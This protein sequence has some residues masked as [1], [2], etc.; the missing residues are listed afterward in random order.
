MPGR[1]KV[2]D[3][4]ADVAQQ[5]LDNIDKGPV[6]HVRSI[7]SQLDVFLNRDRRTTVQN[8]GDYARQ[9]FAPRADLQDANTRP[10]NPSESPH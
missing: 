5:G 6:F 7:Q 10:F 3:D 9:F 8:F 1:N 2:A 4:P